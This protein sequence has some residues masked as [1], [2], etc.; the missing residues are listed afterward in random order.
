VVPGGCN[1]FRVG[2]VK[3]SL[4]WRRYVRECS[5]AVTYRPVEG[6]D[7]DLIKDT[8]EIESVG[9]EVEVDGRRGGSGFLDDDAC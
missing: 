7:W 1:G 5:R 2:S 9:S 4:G 6:V 8:A 3:I